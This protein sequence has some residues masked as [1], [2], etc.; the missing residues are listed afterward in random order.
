MMNERLKAARKALK[1]SQEAFGAKIGLKGSSISY[2]ES[3]RS[4]LTEQTLLAACREF[5][6]NEEWL[7]SGAGEMLVFTEESAIAQ[8]AQEHGLDEFAVRALTAYQKL[9][10]ANRAVIK[11]YIL[12]IAAGYGVE[13]DELR[14]EAEI[15]AKAEAYKEE[16][17]QEKSIET[18]SASPKQ[19]DA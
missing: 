1:L 12:S 18:S 8:L 6:I 7:R 2:I 3:G 19:K 15:A 9:T 16:L 4:S 11:Q 14:E 10:P 5:G 13:L 17:R